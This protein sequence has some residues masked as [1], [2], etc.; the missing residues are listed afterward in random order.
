M[1]GKTKRRDK[2]RLQSS[3]KGNWKEILGDS[4]AE[5]KM[6]ITSLKFLSGGGISQSFLFYIFY[7][8]ISPIIL[9]SCF[10]GLGESKEIR[11][12]SNVNTL[13]K[14]NSKPKRRKYSIN[15]TN[16]IEITWNQRQLEEV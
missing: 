8:F 11:E 3:T 13:A 5:K 6:S 1:G 10:G 2:R 15:E 12:M 4:V 7:I 9:Y 14:D 16:S